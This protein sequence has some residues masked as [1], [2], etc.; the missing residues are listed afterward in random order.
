MKMKTI[1]LALSLAAFAASAAYSEEENY[2]DSAAEAPMAG[3]AEP[4][5]P[6]KEADQMDEKA[7]QMDGKAGMPMPDPASGVSKQDSMGK[8]DMHDDAQDK[9]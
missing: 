7:D 9:R 2:A 5:D 1:L 3:K 4:D 6:V 8:M